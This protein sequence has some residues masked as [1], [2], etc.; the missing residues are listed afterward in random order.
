MDEDEHTEGDDEGYEST[1]KGYQCFQD[2]KTPSVLSPRALHLTNGASGDN[3]L[4]NRL[5]V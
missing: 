1:E 5:Q 4:Y 2:L 3:H